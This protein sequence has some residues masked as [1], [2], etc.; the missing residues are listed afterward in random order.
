MLH[1]SLFCEDLMVGG[2]QGSMV[3]WL[4]KALFW[5]VTCSD[6]ITGDW[7]ASKLSDIM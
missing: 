2:G 3:F 5:L 4:G 1:I 7:H 6:V